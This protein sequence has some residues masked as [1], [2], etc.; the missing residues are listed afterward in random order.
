MENSMNNSKPEHKLTDLGPTALFWS[1]TLDPSRNDKTPCK[2]EI[3]LEYLNYPNF[4]E[5]RKNEH[6][7]DDYLSYGP[8]YEPSTDVSRIEEVVFLIDAYNPGEPDEPI[9]TVDITDYN[10]RDENNN[11]R[12]FFQKTYFVR[13]L[14]PHFPSCNVRFTEVIGTNSNMKIESRLK[15]HGGADIRFYGI[16]WTVGSL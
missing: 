6:A 5:W 16:H 4:R 13:D 1:G 11:P 15:V 9:F 14:S 10:D 7:P 8:Y 3:K 2:Y 12:S